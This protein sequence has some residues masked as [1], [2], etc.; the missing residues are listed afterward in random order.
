MPRFLGELTLGISGMG[1]IARNLAFTPAILYST[2]LYLPYMIP[3][4]CVPE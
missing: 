3:E 2:G 1:A 4:V